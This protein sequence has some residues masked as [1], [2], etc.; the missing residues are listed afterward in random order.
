VG[1]TLPQQLTVTP[2]G[3]PQNKHKFVVVPKLPKYTKEGNHTSLD[4][5]NQ[6]PKTNISL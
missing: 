6:L 5:L 3:A 4:F 1:I 2:S